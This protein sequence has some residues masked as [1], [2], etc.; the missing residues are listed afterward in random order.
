MLV[1]DFSGTGS[2]AP[3]VALL[4]YHIVKKPQHLS[5]LSRLST[6]S[7]SAANVSTSLC[8]GRVLQVLRQE[9]NE[10]H[11]KLNLMI[12]DLD[13]HRLDGSWKPSKHAFENVRVWHLEQRQP[14]AEDTLVDAYID[15]CGVYTNSKLMGVE[16]IEI[17]LA[18]KASLEADCA[19]VG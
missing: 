7:A 14:F 3:K 17:G 4:H 16:Y 15:S 9:P 5:A 18:A 1:R 6:K 8:D 12:V 19:S 11:N 13:A 2:S 10:V